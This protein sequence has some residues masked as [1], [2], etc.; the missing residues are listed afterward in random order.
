MKNTIVNR[1]IGKTNTCL[2]YKTQIHKN[3]K[4]IKKLGKYH[5]PWNNKNSLFIDGTRRVAQNKI[6]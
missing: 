1:K 6:K 5:V 3:T 4:A 2:Q